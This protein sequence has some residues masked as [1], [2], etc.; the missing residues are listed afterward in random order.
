MKHSH[1]SAVR[2]ATAAGAVTIALALTACGS[3]GGGHDE[4]SSAPSGSSTTPAEDGEQNAA[5]ISFA[6]GMIPH[7]Q[8]AVEMADL[9]LDQTTSDE[10]RTL[11]E[12]IRAAQAPEIETL[13]GWLAAWGEAIPEEG[14][15]HS[16]HDMGGD[17]D[18]DGMMSA[19]D[20]TELENASGTA[21]DTAF[22]EMMIEHHRGAVEM[23]ETEQ[24][25]GS[26][27]PALD[28]AEDIISSQTAEIGA[29]N[30]LLG[31]G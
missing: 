11:A 26:Y 13:S 8:Q 25:D 17:M 22:L 19:E 1:R 2:L 31:E 12:Q 10:V 24:A 14:M 5:D 4:D 20:M 23:A 3:D 29:M 6:Q 30:E 27:R 16:D 18:M 7:H 28:M 21:F 9:A 15:D